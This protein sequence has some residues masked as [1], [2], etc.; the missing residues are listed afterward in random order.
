MA[1]K[2]CWFA[3][4]PH[5]QSKFGI[6]SLKI[7][8]GTEETQQASTET[9]P[10]FPSFL[11]SCCQSVLFVFLNRALQ[12]GKGR[13][14]VQ[15]GLVQSHLA[16]GALR[17]KGVVGKWLLHTCLPTACGWA[18]VASTSSTGKGCV[19]KSWGADFQ[20]GKGRSLRCHAVVRTLCWMWGHTTFSQGVQFLDSN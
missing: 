14:P 9:N 6:A 4:L 11:S 10:V 3:Y 16:D 7:R 15:P 2:R 5:S 13:N 8:V 19:F 20:A 18:P 12:R 1:I 17:N